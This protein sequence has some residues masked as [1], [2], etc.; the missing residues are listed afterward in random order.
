MPHNNAQIGIVPLCLKR[1]FNA[2]E[3]AFQIDPILNNLALKAVHGSAVQTCSAGKAFMRGI[4]GS[5][6]FGDFGFDASLHGHPVGYGGS[7]KGW[8]D[9]V[10]KKEEKNDYYP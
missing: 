1:F 5:K 10:Q 2:A 8:K 9:C 6:V 7:G 3:G 4:R